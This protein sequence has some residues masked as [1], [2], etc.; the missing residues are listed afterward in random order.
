MAC[1]ACSATSSNPHQPSN[2]HTTGCGRSAPFVCR[3]HAFRM[4]RAMLPPGVWPFARLSAPRP[5]LLQWSAAMELISLRHM[6]VARQRR[7]VCVWVASNHQSFS[8]APCG[9]EEDN[10]DCH[11]R[12]ASVPDGRVG[13]PISVLVEI[14]GENVR[15]IYQYLDEERVPVRLAL[16]E[17]RKA[18]FAV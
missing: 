11:H 7:N 2:P 16:D 1:S 8:E 18:L 15:Q 13:R 9:R 4:Q 6:I 3:N 12:K 5:F 10:A 17:F 14:P